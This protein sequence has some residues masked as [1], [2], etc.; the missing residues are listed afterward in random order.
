M[1]MQHTGNELALMLEGQKPVSMFYEDDSTPS[2]ESIIPESL[3]D[4]YVDKEL[5]TK[6]SVKFDLAVDPRTNKPITI[7]YVFYCVQG[8]QWRIKA[9]K[10]VLRIMIHMGRADEGIDRII[11]S[12][13]GYTDCENDAYIQSRKG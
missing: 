2:S 3:F 5:F 1:K 10:L 13:L 8:E 11:G 4:Q 12:L 7:R 6:D 9:L